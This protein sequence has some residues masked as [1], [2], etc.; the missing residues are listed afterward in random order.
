MKPLCS[1]PYVYHKEVETTQG[2][3]ESMLADL[4]RTFRRLLAYGK[5]S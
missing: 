2:I 1:L 4:V 5:R 3:F